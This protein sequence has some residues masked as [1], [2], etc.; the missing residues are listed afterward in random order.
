MQS[1]FISH[2][3]Y[4]LICSFNFFPLI[5]HSKLKKLVKHFGVKKWAQIAEQMVGRAGKQCRE[6]WHNHLRPDIKVILKKKEKKISPLLFSFF[7]PSY[8]LIISNEFFS[9]FLK[10]ARSGVAFFLLD[11]LV[12]CQVQLRNL[13]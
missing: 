5:F 11:L 10:F 13:Y 9:C 6:R 3:Q 12:H 7:S 1:W 2:R 8:H 4:C